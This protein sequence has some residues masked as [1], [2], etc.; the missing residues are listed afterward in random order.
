MV[1]CYNAIKRS[2]LKI[3]L[4]VLKSGEVIK[5]NF[6][7]S[8]MKEFTVEAGRIDTITYEKLEIMKKYG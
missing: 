1:L 5:E 8:K 2:K 4:D 7:L 6:D 3:K